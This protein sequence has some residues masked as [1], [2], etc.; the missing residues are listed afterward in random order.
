MRDNP[1]LLD[2]SS[3]DLYDQALAGAPKDKTLYSNRA[4]AKL[5]LKRLDEALGDADA[6]VAVRG[7]A[8]LS[9]PTGERMTRSADR[10][11]SCC[12]RQLDGEWP[13][14]LYRK[15]SV[16][17]EMGRWEEAK[18]FLLKVQRLSPQDKECDAMLEAIDTKLAAR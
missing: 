8:C 16:L 14:G 13:K 10:R 7:V 17:Y 1:L 11:R 6:A 5:K 15:G 2:G 4:L 9:L 18:P 3:T 12:L